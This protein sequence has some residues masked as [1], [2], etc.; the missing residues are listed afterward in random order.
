MPRLR[1]GSLVRI[2]TNGMTINYGANKVFNASGDPSSPVPSG[3]LFPY[4]R[5][6]S[7]VYRVGTQLIQGE[8][9]RVIFRVEQTNQLEVCVNDNPTYLTDN[10]GE[11]RFDITVNETSAE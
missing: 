3:Y 9:G 1:K 5:K 8:A 2:T 10:T 11:M 6:H 7:V 4:Q